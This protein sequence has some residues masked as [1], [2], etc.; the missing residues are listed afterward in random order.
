MDKPPIF[1]VS[2]ILPL[3][4]VSQSLQDSNLPLADNLRMNVGNRQA[5]CRRAGGLFRTLLAHKRKV[6]GFRTAVVMED[7]HPCESMSTRKCSSPPRA[8]E[9]AHFI[10]AR[11]SVHVGASRRW[12]LPWQNRTSIRLPQTLAGRRRR[13][14]WCSLPVPKQSGRA[15]GVRSPSLTRTSGRTW[16]SAY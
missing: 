11:S 13:L 2:L 9:S 14:S 1:P 10:R 16:R 3:S 12:F 5:E 6:S 4:S 15:S 7:R 8:P